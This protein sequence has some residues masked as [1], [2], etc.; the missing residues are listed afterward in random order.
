MHREVLMACVPYG[1]ALLACCA[2][3]RLLV[4]LSGPHLRL[5]RLTQLHRDQSGAV[6]SL[7]FVLT[8]PLFVMVLLF[9]VQLSQLTIGRVVVEYAAFAAA[10]S[11]IVWIPANLGP[12]DEQENRISHI[13]YLGDVAGQDPNT[14]S[15]YEIERQGPKYHKIHFAAAMACLPICPSRNVGEPRNHPGNQAADTLIRLYHAYAPSAAS[16]ARVPT[17]L[18]NKLA[19]ALNNT[20]VRI[21]IRHKDEEPELA[22][23]QQP[24]YP[25]EFTANE[26]GWQDQIVVTI[27]HDFALLPGPGRLLARSSPVSSTGGTSS[28]SGGDSVAQDIRRIGSV[29][30]YPMTATVRLNNEGEKPLL[31]YIQR[32]Y[33]ASEPPAYSSQG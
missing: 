14:Y 21:V 20:R 18:R 33:G 30:V 12:G 11:A 8:L 5:A 4:G 32:T 26:I 7:S 16:N 15:E 29:F 24:P 13:A 25:E 27:E 19:Y 31:P 3:L 17:R 2:C 23:H 6:Q 10:R 1:I 22:E 28:A 9:I